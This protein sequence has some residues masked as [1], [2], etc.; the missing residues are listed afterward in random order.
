MSNEGLFCCDL[1]FKANNIN[2]S[3]WWSRIKVMSQHKILATISAQL[4]SVS[5]SSAACE[6][7][8]SLQNLILSPLRNRLKEETVNKFMSI[9]WTLRRSK[10][11]EKRIH[12]ETES[13]S[14]ES[15]VEQEAE[16]VDEEMIDQNGDKNLL[17]ICLI[18]L[19]IDE[20]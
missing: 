7:G 4:C 19:T 20:M 17:L 3:V 11:K 2:P 15:E 9:E 18:M 12:L 6:R 8:W 10:Q 14:S 13:D 16:Q 5:A 1:L